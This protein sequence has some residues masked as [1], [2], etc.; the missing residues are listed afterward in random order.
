MD[1]V[2]SGEL[3]SL[4]QSQH[5][6]LREVDAVGSGCVLIKREGL[7]RLTMMIKDQCGKISGMR[8]S[9]EGKCGL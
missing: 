9:R 7:R 3:K 5:K 4:P 8:R 6:G 2:E 1:K